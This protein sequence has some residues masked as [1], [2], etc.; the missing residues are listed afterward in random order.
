M[1]ST[2]E[3][4]RIKGLRSISDSG[5]IK[6]KPITIL[7]GKNSVGKSTIARMFPLLKQTIESTRTSSVLWFGKRVDFG[8]FEDSISSHIDTDEIEFNLKINISTK[9]PRKSLLQRKS[10]KQEDQTVER[11]VFLRL[12]YDNTLETE[13][14]SEF[15]AAANDFSFK[16]STDEFQSVTSITVDDYKWEIPDSIATFVRFKSLLPDAKFI[17]NSTQEGIGIA[18]AASEIKTLDEQGLEQLAVI[19]NFTESSP[20]DEAV[21]IFDEINNLL[22]RENKTFKKINIPENQLKMLLKINRIQGVIN[23]INSAAE[24]YFESVGY[25][26]PIRAAAQRYNRNQG[27][28]INEID[29]QGKN[30]TDFLAGISVAY[31]HELNEWLLEN[32][33]FEIRIHNNNNHLS[34]MIKDDRS[35]DFVNMADMGFGF[36]QML[37]ILVQSWWSSF[38]A[39]TDE[40]LKLLIIEQPELHLHPAYQAQLADIFVGIATLPGDKKSNLIIETHSN[41]IINRLSLL[42]ATG[43]IPKDSIQILVFEKNN[44]GSTIISNSEFNDDGILNNW[45]VGFFEPPPPQFLFSKK[46][47]HPKKQSDSSNDI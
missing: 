23:S 25:I 43:K 18:Y 1:S 30:L 9:K 8:S 7:V 4:F 32:F 47:R 36:S 21:R 46:E 44:E 45:P 40:N 28:A 26:E 12:K 6:I 3:S 19:L 2:L 39:T 10:I 13:F 22:H 14:T 33:S 16:I 38:K 24:S 37:P 27:T 29:S 17:C 35:A 11:N 5:E 31:I 20:L 15:G 41:H 42:V 34:I